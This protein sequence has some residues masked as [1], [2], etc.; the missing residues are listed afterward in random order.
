MSAEGIRAGGILAAGEGSRLRQAGW[1]MPKPLVPVAGVPLVEHVVGNFRAA[2]VRSLTVIF[3]EQE[4]PCADWLRSRFPDLDLRII[5][6]TTG[7]SLESFH[8]IARRLSGGR[9]LFSTVDAWCPRSDFEDFL[10]RAAQ[11]PADATVLAVTPFVADE[12]PLWV[13]L[14]VAGHVR[15]LGATPAE[16][17]TAGMY[18]VPERVWRITPPEHLARLR[19]FLAWLLER[20][21]SLCG[22][23]IPTVVDVDRPEDVALA[24]EL[25]NR[26]EN[27]AR[28]GAARRAVRP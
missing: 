23:S 17:V 10:R 22:V 18:L 16:M 12:R 20:G 13:R 1:R 7:S 19:E 6:K 21:E 3:N 5:V 14:D 27:A 11:T 9:V 8:E 26:P 4:Q 15:E 24:E 28:F 2:G 25:A